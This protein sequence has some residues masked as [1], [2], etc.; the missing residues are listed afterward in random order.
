MEYW[1]ILPLGL[2]VPAKHLDIGDLK[3]NDLSTFHIVSGFQKV[4]KNITIFR[5]DQN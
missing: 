4:I 2:Q 5:L 1:V 3:E